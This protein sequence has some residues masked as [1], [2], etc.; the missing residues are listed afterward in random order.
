[1]PRAAENFEKRY[2]IL[3][4]FANGGKGGVGEGSPAGG[5]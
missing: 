5:G 3:K 4:N 2:I 1:M